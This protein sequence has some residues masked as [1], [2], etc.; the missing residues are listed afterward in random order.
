MPKAA[1]TTKTYTYLEEGEDGSLVE[2]EIEIEGWLA[3]MPT[4]IAVINS[5]A[6]DSVVYEV[7]RAC[8]ERHLV[9][10]GQ[11]ADPNDED[12]DGTP[13][14]SYKELDAS[15]QPMTLSQIPTTKL[16][17]A[18]SVAPAVGS[19]R[20]GSS[21]D[22]RGQRFHKAQLIGQ[23]TIMRGG[24]AMKN[25][26]TL[27]GTLVRFDEIKAGAVVARIMNGETGLRA[28]STIRLNLTQHLDYLFNIDPN[29]GF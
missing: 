5:G 28:G 6:M 7:A 4:V 19:T 22:Y 20:R 24:V 25:G 17:N 29:G 13:T 9:L 16:I 14:P 1:D 8:Y 11:Q 15:F 21:F 12:S 18:G 10:T 23:F 2:T 26:K 3:Y 27:D